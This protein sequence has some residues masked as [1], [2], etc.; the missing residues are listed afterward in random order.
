MRS[1][2]FAV[3]LMFAALL[4]VG[5]ATDADKASDNLG[6]DAEQFKVARRI[7][8]INGITDKVEFEVTGRCSIESA[9]ELGGVRALAIVCKEKDAVKGKP[10]EYKKHFVGLS[11]NMFFVSTQLQGINVSVYRSKIILKPQNIVPD[12]DLVTGG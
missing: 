5:C 2:A 11:D 12:L 7:V 4:V 3:I 1:T 6:K 9:T 10:A 8:G